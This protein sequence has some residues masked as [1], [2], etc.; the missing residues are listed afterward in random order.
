M[1]CGH[2]WKVEG[3]SREKEGDKRDEKH[4]RGRWGM[5]QSR[6]IVDERSM[7]RKASKAAV[8]QRP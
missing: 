2:D 7:V 3:G 5:K 4:Y 1:W 6:I 8:A